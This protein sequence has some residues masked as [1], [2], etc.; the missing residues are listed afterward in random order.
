MLPGTSLTFTVTGT[1]GVVFV[2]TVVSNTAYVIAVNPF[3][4]SFAFTNIRTGSPDVVG[5]I[6]LPDPAA[7]V[8]MKNRLESPEMEGLV[9]YKI[10]VKNAGTGKITSFVFEDT[11]HNARVTSSAKADMFMVE[12]WFAAPASLTGNPTA[13]KQ[14]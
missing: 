14:Y 5:T 2:P 4:K 10:V 8:V 7:S 1:I 9:T 3:G 6:V 12:S 13:R 11:T